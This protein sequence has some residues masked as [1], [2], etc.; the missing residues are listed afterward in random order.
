MAVFFSDV[1]QWN[2]LSG[3]YFNAL[4]KGVGGWEKNDDR[5]NK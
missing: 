1:P 2:V 3:I 4:H 5:T